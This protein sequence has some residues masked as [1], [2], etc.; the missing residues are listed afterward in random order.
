MRGTHW[1][2][3]YCT[4]LRSTGAKVA[5][6]PLTD[7]CPPRVAVKFVVRWRVDGFPHPRKRTFTDPA[8]AENWARR[9]EAAR[10]LRLPCDDSG[11]PVD[12]AAVMV[13]PA[14]DSL[15]LGVSVGRSQTAN[16]G[17]GAS[18]RPENGGEEDPP[19]YRW[20]E[21][22]PSA[23]LVGHQTSGARPPGADMTTTTVTGSTPD[24]LAIALQPTPTPDRAGDEAGLAREHAVATTPM[25]E[26]SSRP[27]V[28]D[29]ATYIDELIMLYR[30]VWEEQ[31]DEGLG[32]RWWIGQLEFL[33]AVLR[34][35]PSDDPDT[36]GVKAGDPLHFRHLGERHLNR[37]LQLRRT[38]NLRVVHQNKQR[39][40]K[41]ERD[42][43]KYEAKVGAWQGRPGHKGRKPVPPAKPKQAVAVSHDGS[44]LVSTH[45][46]KGFRTALSFVF[47]R[48]FDE[49]LFPPGPNPYRRWNPRG[50]GGRHAARRS[51]FR[52]VRKGTA[53][54]RSFPGLGFFVDLGDVLAEHGRII[55]PGVRAG[56]RYR[57]LP[58]TLV[59]I[60]PRP[61]EACRLREEH[62]TDVALI[63][64]DPGGHLK[65]RPTG[66]TRTVP[67]SRL[68]AGLAA[69]HIAAGLAGSDGTLFM[70]PQGDPLD[71]GNFYEDYLRPSIRHL[72]GTGRLW[73]EYPSLSA[74]SFY[75]L[76][77]A[78]ITTWVAHGADTHEA[79]RWSGHT[80]H[81]LLTSYR[82]VIDGVGRRAT[83]KG[84]DSMVEEAL[85]SQPPRG[86]GPLAVR[87]RRWLDL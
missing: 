33:K 26:A 31:G 50:S 40:E 43:A 70:S 60:A 23:R 13:A 12:A 56:E 59:T 82:G 87:L 22:G 10:V 37:A 20:S 8:A 19:N 3:P 21:R 45:A 62:L 72:S 80:E 85:L 68:V 71:L 55:A 36:L 63:A 46:E 35:D 32:A 48:A 29:V 9:I 53:E 79:S 4:A 42:L 14:P 44:V 78:G 7:R 34:Y 58:L 69:E 15:A 61:R 2:G 11:G 41:Y 25:A 49:G 6:D 51:P 1:S 81:E 83:W 67:L 38:V 5:W 18:R 39:Q 24:A 57:V 84:I 86:D 27:R 64:P 16:A 47:D 17:G 75:D 76:R 74:A 77:K 73:D 52:S 66:E 30:P 54:D 65:H 28:R